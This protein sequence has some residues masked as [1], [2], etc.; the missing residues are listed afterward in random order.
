MSAI[1]QIEK[2]LTDHNIK[3]TGKQ[4]NADMDIKR[5]K[6]YYN[7]NY[8]NDV[9]MYHEGLVMNPAFFNRNPNLSKNVIGNHV[10]KSEVKHGQHIP[11]TYYDDVIHK[12][13]TDGTVLL[14][15]GLIVNKNKIL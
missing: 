11:N 14:G 10:M 2:Y 12:D 5:D 6:N 1:T 8:G 13:K 9:S 3:Y 7:P 15:G 4:V